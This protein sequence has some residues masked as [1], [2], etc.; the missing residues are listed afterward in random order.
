MI[1]RI[2]EFGKFLEDAAQNNPENE[3]YFLQQLAERVN[4]TD[5]NIILLTTLHQDFSAYA[6]RLDKALR[7]EWDKVKGRFKEITFNEPVEQLLLLAS[8]RLK[9]DAFDYPSDNLQGL[10]AI[11]DQS[12]IFPLRD[13]FNLEIAKN[14]LP[15]T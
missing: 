12:H 9:K 14:L 15:L 7:N 3:I 10:N 1:I 6:Y 2:D 8:E 5:K 11:I 13:F 4:N